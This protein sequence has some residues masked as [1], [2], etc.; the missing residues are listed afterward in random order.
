MISYAWR[1]APGGALRQVPGTYFDVDSVSG[2]YESSIELDSWSRMV[3]LSA[4]A[5]DELPH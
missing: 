3:R 5:D 2:T 1:L 4:A